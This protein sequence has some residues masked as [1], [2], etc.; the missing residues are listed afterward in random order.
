M[1][2]R[3]P[4]GFRRMIA[5]AA[6][7]GRI[8]VRADPVRGASGAARSPRRP[9][10]CRWRLTRARIRECIAAMRPLGMD[11][12]APALPIG[13]DAPLEQILQLT[14]A[15]EEGNTAVFAT[16]LAG[17]PPVEGVTAE[18]R[19][20][21][22]GQG[23]EVTLFIHRPVERAA[24]LPGLVHLHGGGMTILSAADGP[25]VRW[26]D[27]LAAAGMVVVGV[28]FRNAGGKLGPH[29]FPAGLDDCAAAVRWVDAHRDE[30][31]VEALLVSG[32]SGGG[33]LTLAVTH[34]A[35]RE[36]WLD[37]IDGVYAQCPYISG[38]WAAPP[39]DLPSLRENDDYFIGCGAH[40]HPGPGL[41]PRWR[42]RRRPRVLAVRGHR[43][44]PAGHAAPR[45]L[46]QR[47]RPA[48]RRGPR[49]L[50]PAGRR[51]GA[52]HGPHR[53]RHLPRAATFSSPAP[54]PRPTRPASGTSKASPTP[55]NANAIHPDRIRRQ[56]R[57]S[58]NSGSSIR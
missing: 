40:G 49:L 19:V 46:G 20:I 29:P 53:Q 14:L 10:A 55:S 35:R 16:L 7:E 32:E 39:A 33:N 58:G 21:S 50:P 34:R 43:R 44:R 3:G 12:P 27:E 51:R 38:L 54:S 15:A 57:H 37:A 1:K 41:R 56:G 45:H 18:T 17:L 9:G 2:A 4:L 31:G 28:E 23:N 25:Y 47:A 8:H 26:R 52:R 22:G 6:S 5:R 24:R 11:Q 48:A 13:P 36:G 30:L 42:P